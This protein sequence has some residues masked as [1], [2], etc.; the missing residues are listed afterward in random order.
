MTINLLTILDYLQNRRQSGKS[1]R[2][3]DFLDYL[4]KEIILLQS[5]TKG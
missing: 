5:R 4:Q 1:E 2:N 3:S